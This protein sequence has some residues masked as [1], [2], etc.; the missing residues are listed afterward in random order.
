MFIDGRVH[1]YFIMITD[2][3]NVA[4][5]FFN[6]FYNASYGAAITFLFWTSFFFF[7]LFY[8]SIS[9]CFDPWILCHLLACFSEFLVVSRAF[10]DAV[11]ASYRAKTVSCATCVVNN[12]LRNSFY[13]NN[14][15]YVQGIRQILVIQLP[16]N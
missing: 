4:I 14:F 3:Q 2:Q 5:H 7:R 10:L 1:S 8:N 12:K 16:D 9:P 13:G 11:N 6:R 15:W